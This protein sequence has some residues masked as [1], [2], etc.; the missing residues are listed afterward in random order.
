MFALFVPRPTFYASLAHVSCH[1]FVALRMVCPPH[2]V[3]DRQEIARRASFA[4]TRIDLI[5]TPAVIFEV[6][7]SLSPIGITGK[8]G[9][10]GR[11]HRVDAFVT[12]AGIHDAK[13]EALFIRPAGAEGR[14]HFPE[15]RTFGRYVLISFSI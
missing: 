8:K 1:T 14:S 9:R 10:R 11:D 7:E 12:L 5:F 2:A 13:F 3:L 6:W 15:V 4:G